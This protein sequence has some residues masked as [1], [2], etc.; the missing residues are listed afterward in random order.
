[1]ALFC[2][3]KKKCGDVPTLIYFTHTTESEGKITKRSYDT[4]EV[5]PSK[6]F[7]DG[8]VSDKYPDAEDINESIDLTRSK[9]REAIRSLKRRR[10]TPTAELVKEVY[11]NE[12]K[13]IA[14]VMESAK[15][16]SFDNSEKGGRRSPSLTNAVISSLGKYEKI[17]GELVFSAMNNKFFVDYYE[18]LISGK[19]SRRS[20][21]LINNTVIQYIARLVMFMEWAEEQGLHRQTHHAKWKRHFLNNYRVL[22][23]DREPLLLD[24]IKKIIEGRDDL[25]KDEYNAVTKWLIQLFTSVRYSDVQKM[26]WYMFSDDCSF[27]AKRAKK[28][29]KEVRIYVHP[30]GIE[31]LQELR[32]KSTGIKS[33]VIEHLGNPLPYRNIEH[34]KS[35]FKRLGIERVTSVYYAKGDEVIEEPLSIHEMIGTHMARGTYATHYIASNGING[36][37]ET[38]GHSDI[39]T[40]MK[41]NKTMEVQRRQSQQQAFDL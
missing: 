14:T 39:K 4:G 28:T 21:G 8:R 33:L 41:Y 24:E 18:G 25:P 40:T 27:F 5:C 10:I 31:I 37:Q 34:L 9:I 29:T 35:A 20:G 3:Q 36:L 7:K 22:S 38:L 23:K 16:W 12:N 1:M 26:K 11:E 13:A 6:F 30:K 2:H 17:N 19:Y 15:K 32:A